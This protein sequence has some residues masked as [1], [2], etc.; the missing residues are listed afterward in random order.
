MLAH[1]DVRNDRIRARE[2]ATEGRRAMA[3]RAAPH[4]GRTDSGRLPIRWVID[5]HR[6]SGSNVSQCSAT[7]AAGA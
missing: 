6:A 2:R 1:V 3:V 4:S 7:A 5:R